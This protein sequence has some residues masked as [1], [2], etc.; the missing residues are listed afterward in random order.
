MTAAEIIRESGWRPIA[1]APASLNWALCGRWN[2]MIWEEIEDC[3]RL[4][5]E[6]D[7]THYF[8]RP[9]PPAREVPNDGE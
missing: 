1:E 4:C 8:V 7:W 9:N 2:G 5:A 6:L 3:P